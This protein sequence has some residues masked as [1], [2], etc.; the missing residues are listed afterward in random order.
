MISTT[1]KLSSAA[2]YIVFAQD[3]LQVEAF[4]PGDNQHPVLQRRNLPGGGYAW[5]QEDD[6]TYNVRQI[7]GNWVIEKRGKI[8][9]KQAHK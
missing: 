5:N 1:D 3:S 4:V 6:D 7:D 9:Y 8:L 2:A